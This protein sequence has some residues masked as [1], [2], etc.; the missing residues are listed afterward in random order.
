MHAIRRSVSRV[1]SP[2]RGIRRLLIVLGYS[3]R[4]VLSIGGKKYY[5]SYQ[6]DDEDENADPEV[7]LSGFHALPH[8]RLI[9]LCNLKRCRDCGKHMFKPH[10]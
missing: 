6:Q 7:S 9:A 1:I 8:T 4:T 10:L 3:T 2:G 5:H